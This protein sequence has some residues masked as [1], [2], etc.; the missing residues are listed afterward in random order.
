[1]FHKSWPFIFRRK[2]RTKDCTKSSPNI[3][4]LLV[5]SSSGVSKR[6]SPTCEE[7]DEAGTVRKKSRTDAGP[8]KH[9]FKT[10]CKKK[11]DE[12]SDDEKDS[13]ISQSIKRKSSGDEEEESAVRKKSRTEDI[14]RSIRFSKKYMGIEFIQRGGF[15]RVYSGV[16]IEDNLPVVLKLIDKTM[17]MDGKEVTIPTEVDFLI[18]AGAGPNST[19][20]TFTPRLLD[21]YDLGHDIVLVMEKPESCMDLVDYALSTE[22][23]GIS[24]QKVKI[25]FRQLVDA[26]IDLHSRGIFHRDI[27]PEN[28]LVEVSSNNPRTW[29]IDYGQRPFL[30]LERSFKTHKVK[31][32]TLDYSSP[33]WFKCATYTAEPTTVWQ[34]GLVLYAMLFNGLPLIGDEAI[35]LMRTIPIPPNILPPEATHLLRGC[36]KKNPR[37]RLSLQDIKDH[38]WLNSE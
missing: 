7:E 15:G 27:K 34:L 28:I 6:K 13:S 33:E 8:Q 22:D 17:E 18:K 12:T 1:M 11:T 38:P 2:K 30:P 19:E 25:I 16:R 31:Y 26:A 9:K 21:W 14:Q 23:T 24:R 3:R 10:V 29:L 5:H 35:A 32:W 4:S 37:D 20:S 36:L